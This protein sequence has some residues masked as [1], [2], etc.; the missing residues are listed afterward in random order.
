QKNKILRSWYSTKHYATHWIENRGYKNRDIV[1]GFRQ[2]PVCF[3]CAGIITFYAGQPL[4]SLVK[5]RWGAILLDNTGQVFRI[6]FAGVPGNPD[7]L[8]KP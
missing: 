2:I 4:D 1:E 5:I 6:E 3:V 7:G 8:L